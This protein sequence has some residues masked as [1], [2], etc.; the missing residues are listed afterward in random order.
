MKEEFW[1]ELLDIFVSHDELKKE[2]REL[3][4]TICLIVKTTELHK[5]LEELNKHLTELNT[6]KEEK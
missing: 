2:H 6:R 1:K 3:Y 5:E 4:E